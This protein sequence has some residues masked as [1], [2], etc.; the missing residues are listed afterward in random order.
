L[1]VHHRTYD[2]LYDEWHHL[3]DLTTLCRVCHSARHLRCKSK[4]PLRTGISWRELY[5]RFSKLGL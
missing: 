5:E 2:H 1:D 4:N 3:D